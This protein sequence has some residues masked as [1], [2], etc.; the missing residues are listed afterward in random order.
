MKEDHC[1]FFPEGSWSHCCQS[2]DKAYELQVD[3]STADLELYNCVKEASPTGIT[4]I[5]AALMFVGV[6]LLGKKFYRK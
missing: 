6:S 2:H 1:T 4:W 5:V 3:K